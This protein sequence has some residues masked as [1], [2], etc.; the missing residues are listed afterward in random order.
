M[1]VKNL[2]LGKRIG[3]VLI[4]L[5]LIIFSYDVTFA[6]DDNSNG[7]ETI[8]HI[9]LDY[10]HIGAVDN[11]ELIIDLIDQ[12][13]DEKAEEDDSFSYALKQELTMLPE[14]VFNFNTRNEE[15]LTKLED[16]V[17]IHIE[18]TALQ[19]GGQ[20]VGYFNELT[21]AEQ[22]IDE[23]KGIYVDEEAVLDEEDQTIDLATGDSII[24]DV[25]LSDEVT[26]EGAVVAENELLTIEEGVE[27]LEKGTLEDQIHLVEAG[28]VLFSI[29]QSYDLTMDQLLEL[30]PSLEEDDLLQIDQEINVTDYAPYVDVIVEKHERVEETIDYETIVEQSDELYRGESRVEQ[31]GQEGKREV[32]YEME[33]VNGAVVDK[34]VIEEEI[35]KDVVDKII[36]EGTKVIP[37][38]GTGDFA[39]PAV[40]GQITSHY[41]PRWGSHHDGIDI[42]GVSNRSILAADNGTVEF[43]GYHNG[44]YGNKVIINHNNGYKTVYAHLAS[45]DV[46]VGQTVPKG[47][48]IGVM[49]TS[50]RSTGVHLHFEVFRNGS[51]INP[52]NVLP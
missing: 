47:T 31:T 14:R 1:S 6:G 7:L 50:G 42:A 9:Y 19:I 48:T 26:Y 5:T 43:A 28:D 40:G 37:S 18:A 20:V 24:V 35:T 38:R 13:I 44:G 52:V 36:I 32:Q 25:S 4:I 27:L 3:Q 10:E 23:Y 21:K 16:D 49:G 39:W 51:T 15:A 30:N 45:I 34:E 41:G 8:Y 11:D 12:L 22:V 46:Q 33:I 29:A 2:Q 17:V